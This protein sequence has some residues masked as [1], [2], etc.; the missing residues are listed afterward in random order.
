MTMEI[1]EI[2]IFVI[3]Q[4]ILRITTI[5]LWILSFVY[6]GM[7]LNRLLTTEISWSRLFNHT[8]EIGSNQI[9]FMVGLKLRPMVSPIPAPQPPAPT[10]DSPDSSSASRAA[11]PPSPNSYIPALAHLPSRAETVDTLVLSVSKSSWQL[12]QRL[13]TGLDRN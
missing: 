1:Y 6:V 2:F 4:M 3:L 13:A 9:T 5:P 12:V 10:P 11:S 8:I 7:Q